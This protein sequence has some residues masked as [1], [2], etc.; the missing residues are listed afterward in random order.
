MNTHLTHKNIVLYSS[1]MFRR[2]LRHLQQTLHQNLNL[3]KYNRLQ[4]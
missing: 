4:K 1:Y 3:L 2:P